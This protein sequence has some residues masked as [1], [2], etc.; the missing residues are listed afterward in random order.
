MGKVEFA[1]RNGLPLTANALA[2]LRRSHT[3]KN[4]E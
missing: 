2:G 4:K 1:N 3:T